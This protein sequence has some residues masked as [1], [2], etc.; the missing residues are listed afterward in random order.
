MSHFE[1]VIETEGRATISRYTGGE[2]IDLVIPSKIGANRVYAIGQEA[3]SRQLKF[4]G[5]VSISTGIE[6]I[7]DRAFA[8]C[9]N[10]TRVTIAST[11]KSIGSGAFSNCP[12]LT[13]VKFMGNAPIIAPDAFKNSSQVVL[14]YY[15]DTRGWAPEVT[16]RF[17]ISGAVAIQ[18]EF[19]GDAFIGDSDDE[20]VDLGD[21]PEGGATL[22][23]FNE[24][25][26]TFDEPFD[27][28]QAGQ[29]V[30][31]E[32]ELV[33]EE[34]ADVPQFEME[35]I[36]YMNEIKAFE[37]T[38]YGFT[39][40]TSLKNVTNPL[41]AFRIR[42]TAAFYKLQAAAKMQDGDLVKLLDPISLLPNI[43]FKNPAAYVL[44][45]IASRGGREVSGKSFDIACKISHLINEKKLNVTDPDI[46]RYA[47]YWIDT[48]AEIMK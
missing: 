24:T 23:T 38:G 21:E 43:K 20:P 7:R 31:D 6:E 12:I 10:L 14:K 27:E 1:Y 4:I 19:T 36:Q 44:G 41:E 39:S 3:F 22:G 13:E 48:I 46:L 15:P 28:T 2:N 35:E 17:A 18:E 5:S 16:R 30:F 8:G 29:V 42:T 34:E 40:S 9:R 11:V 25:L 45:Y 33:A 26:G 37:R 47:V 32:Q